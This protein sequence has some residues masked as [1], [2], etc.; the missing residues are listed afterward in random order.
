MS[1][2]CVPIP[3]ASHSLHT[4]QFLDHWLPEYSTRLVPRA[5]SL[6]SLSAPLRG[7]LCSRSP[8]H[9]PWGFTP[10]PW[11]ASRGTSAA[12]SPASGTSG[13]PPSR[14]WAPTQTTTL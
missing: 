6:V 10:N 3:A 9:F 12:L 4:L 5:E 2:P 1:L 7:L 13:D 14:Y 11:P 8:T